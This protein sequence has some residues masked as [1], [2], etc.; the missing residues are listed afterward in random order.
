MAFKFS[1]KIWKKK[2]LKELTDTNRELE[3]IT[4]NLEQRIG[5]RTLELEKANQQVQE[6]ATRLQIIS[7]I[8]QEITSNVDQQAQGVA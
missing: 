1:A 6:R 5:A 3:D 4:T 2:S 7:E 8:S